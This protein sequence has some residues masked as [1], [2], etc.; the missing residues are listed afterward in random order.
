MHRGNVGHSPP[1]HLE[2]WF[3]DDRSHDT[4]FTL[5]RKHAGD[6]PTVLR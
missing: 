6:K 5:A 4:R 1:T 2:P 3:D